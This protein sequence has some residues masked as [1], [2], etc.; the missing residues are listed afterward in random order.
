MEYTSGQ[1][2]V[3]YKAYLSALSAEILKSATEVLA[4]WK[5]GYR[6]KFVENTD[7]NASGSISLMV[8]AYVQYYEKIFVQLR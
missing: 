4:D 3:A 6:N 1:E 7:S 5:G 8:N 2:A